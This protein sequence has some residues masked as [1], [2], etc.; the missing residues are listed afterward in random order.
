MVEV[1]TVAGRPDIEAVKKDSL[2]AIFSGKISFVITT[3]AILR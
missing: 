3:A 2:Q 1:L